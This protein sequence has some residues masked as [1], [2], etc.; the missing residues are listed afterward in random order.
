ML[1]IFPFI[2]YLSFLILPKINQR[3]IY[4]TIALPASVLVL[5]F[6]S[7][8]IIER[9]IEFP[10]FRYLTLPAGVFIL[11]AS[12]AISL[13]LVFKKQLLN[14]ANV[15]SIGILL[16]ILT[17][18]FSTQRLNNYIGF[19]NLAREAQKIGNERDIK[20]YFFYQFRSGENI[21]SYLKKEIKSTTLE[22]L[23][24]IEKYMIL[25]SW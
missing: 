9:Y 18:S 12:A 17:T 1:P 24:K 8:F 23:M 14:A 21:D 4:I 13:I 7:L 19:G 10:V 22:Q 2:T 20:N 16:L 6:P 15:V 3:F 5:A 25:Y 11:S